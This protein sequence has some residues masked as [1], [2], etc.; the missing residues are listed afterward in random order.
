MKVKSDVVIA[1]FCLLKTTSIPADVPAIQRVFFQLSAI[2][3]GLFE[4]FVFDE[5]R[6]RPS[7]ETV[8]FAI[9]ILSLS[10]FI[11]WHSQRNEYNLERLQENKKDHLG[12]FNENELIILGLA[13]KK[14]EELI[15][16]KAALD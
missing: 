3:R 16:S 12:L 4:G 11:Y 13:A 5:S 6:G 15:S 14:F 1:V 9:D 2:F 10:G 8:K 7:C